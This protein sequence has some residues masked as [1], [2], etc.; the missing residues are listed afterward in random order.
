MQGI[1]GTS[2]ENWKASVAKVC[3][4]PLQWEPGSKTEYHGNTGMLISAE[5]VRRVSGRKPWEE[6]CR[7]RIF[8]PLGLT[9]F[10]FVA[11]P[12]DVLLI[13][14][15]EDLTIGAAHY[16]NNT[17]LP[18]A[19]CYANPADLLKFLTFQTNRGSWQGKQLMEEKYW[20]AM[21][22][23]Q[24]PGKKGFSPWGFGMMLGGAGAGRPGTG[25]FGIRDQTSSTVFS[26]VGTSCVMA[27]GDPAT[28]L[29]ITFFTSDVPSTKPKAEEMRNT[30]TNKIL[31]A[32]V[33]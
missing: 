30:V 8:A 16:H 23:D 28:D 9:S 19:G 6:I 11:P 15:P 22:A 26:H 20:T 2:E 21:H 3:A 5:A 29:E 17:G 10:T 27:V 13:E 25:W 4:M 14:P 18:A 33:A 31:G 24:F 12:G 32:V 1:S 7:E